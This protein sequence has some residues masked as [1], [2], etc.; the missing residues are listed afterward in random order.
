MVYEGWWVEEHNAPLFT[1]VLY[2][3]AKV[4]DEFPILAGQVLICSFDC[5][6][7]T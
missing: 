5:S 7:E 6:N 4:Q 3:I 2:L 1:L